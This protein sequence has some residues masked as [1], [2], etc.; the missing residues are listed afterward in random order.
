MIHYDEYE[1]IV[2]QIY[3]LVEHGQMDRAISELRK[4]RNAMNSSGRAS[5]EELKKELQGM[6]MSW[7]PA[8]LMVVVES[9]L[10]HKCFVEGGMARVIAKAEDEFWKL[11]HARNDCR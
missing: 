2:L 9:A 5:Y 8:I 7:H 6:P 11:G 1:N 4:F 10:K 3:D